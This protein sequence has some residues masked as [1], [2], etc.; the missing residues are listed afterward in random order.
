MSFIENAYDSPAWVSPS[1]SG[2]PPGPAPHHDLWITCDNPVCGVPGG[3]LWGLHDSADP[4][5]VREYLEANG[6]LYL[7]EGNHHCDGCNPDYTEE[8]E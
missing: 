8:N 7:P 4:D 1:V 6:W 5:A 2:F 3:E